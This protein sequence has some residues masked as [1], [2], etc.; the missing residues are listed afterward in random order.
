MNPLHDFEFSFIPDLIGEY[1][2]G[3]LPV[4]VLSDKVRMQIQVF[5][6]CRD[7]FVPILDRT[8]IRP[9]TLGNGILIFYDFP[10]P[11]E[12]TD[13]RYG[14]VLIRTD[15]T[16]EYHTLEL[17]SS[18]RYAH[19]MVDPDRHILIDFFPSDTTIDEFSDLVRKVSDNEIP[20]YEEKGL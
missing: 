14:A 18:G 19:C 13:A 7:E 4:E 2:S 17:T 9:E 5:L 8:E 3:K 15:G 11:E 6:K 1:V 12:V 20:D 10:R 16:P